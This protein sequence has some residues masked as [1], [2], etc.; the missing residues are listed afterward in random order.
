MSRNGRSWLTRWPPTTTLPSSPGMAVPGQWPGPRSRV[1]SVTPSHSGVLDP[2]LRDLDGAQLHAGPALLDRAAAAGWAAERR[3]RG[4]ERGGNRRGDGDGHGGRC[5]LGRLGGAAVRDRVSDVGLGAR[6]ARRETEHQ[7]H[8]AGDDRGAT[9][10]CAGAWAH[11]LRGRR[12]RLTAAAPS[13]GCCVGLSARGDRSWPAPAAAALALRC[14]RGRRGRGTPLLPGAGRSAAVSRS[15]QPVDPL[16]VPGR[17]L[18]IEPHQ[19]DADRRRL[20]RHAQVAVEVVE[21]G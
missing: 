3:R 9:N 18:G 20:A 6:S 2:D 1:G 10:G 17:V 8:E 16:E 5:G 12:A 4:G 13:R 15:V 19:R 21:D 14:R 7:P 11:S